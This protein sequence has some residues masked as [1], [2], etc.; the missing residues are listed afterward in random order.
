MATIFLAV[1]AGTVSN[2]VAVTPLTNVC[3]GPSVLGGSVT[4]EFAPTQTGPWNTAFTGSTGGSYRSLTNAWVRVTAVTSQANAFFSDMGPALTD[5]SDALLSFGATLA[6]PSATA[7]GILASFR[8][9]PN[10]LTPNFRMI[11]TGTLNLTNNAN[12]KTLNIYANGLAGTALGTSPSLASIA[13]YTFSHTIYGTTGSTL[14]GA[15]VL[16]SQTAAQGGFGST[17]TALPTLARDYLGQ[18][19]EFVVGLTKATGTDTG[20][21]T[22]LTVQLFN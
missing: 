18:E 9:P 12:V 19:T 3:A 17:T 2:P 10:F 8:I 22:A 6:S 14:T 5:V 21:L 1:A 7:A 20:E 13:N 15:G 11:I 4:V 16:S